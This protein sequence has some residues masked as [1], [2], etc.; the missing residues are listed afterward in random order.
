MP[1]GERTLHAQWHSWPERTYDVVV[2]AYEDFCDRRAP[3]LEASDRVFHRR[4]SKW[5][6]V[7]SVIDELGTDIDAYD[8]IWIPDDDIFIRAPDVD[9]LFDLFERHR[10][11]LAQ[12][13]LSPQS[14]GSFAAL[15]R[16]RRYLYRETNFVEVMAPIFSR[17]AL[18]R[19]TPTMTQT[20]SGWGLDYLWSQHILA[21]EK[22]GVIDAVAMT[23]VAPVSHDRPSPDSTYARLDLSP[24]TDL[25][26][27]EAEHGFERRVRTLRRRHDWAG[28]ARRLANGPARVIRRLA[29]ARRS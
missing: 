23:H 4:G 9:R 15:V 25:H 28:L 3:V 13:A 6:I 17:E 19:V 20:D 5:S 18:R 12:P 26:S 21:N 27:L 10:F 16:R 29:R 1:V 24:W 14:H 11:A 7:A 2:I 8:T 22:V